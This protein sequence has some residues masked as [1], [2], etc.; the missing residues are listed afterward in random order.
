VHY[1]LLQHLRNIGE[2]FATCCAALS[3]V[4]AELQDKAVGSALCA[5]F[6]T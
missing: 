2:L 6:N 3:Q 5:L 4:A 1:A